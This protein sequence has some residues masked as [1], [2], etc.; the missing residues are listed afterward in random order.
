MEIRSEHQPDKSIIFINKNKLIGIENESFQNLI[1]ESIEKGSRTVSVDLSKVEYITSWGVGVLVHAY[2]TCT[3]RDVKFNLM[4]VNENVL[5]VLHQ[6]K[7]D[8]L[9]DIKTS[10]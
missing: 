9:F 2:T 3:N 7:L 8:K 10:T 5:Q 6:I 4:S 1:L